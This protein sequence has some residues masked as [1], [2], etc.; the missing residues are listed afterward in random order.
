MGIEMRWMS[1]SVSPIASGANPVGACAVVTPR[2]TNT[3]N[4]VSRI[5]TRSTATSEKPPGECSP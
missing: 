4:A 1:V 3:K 2:I 5:S